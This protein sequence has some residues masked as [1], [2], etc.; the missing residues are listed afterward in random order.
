MLG[1]GAGIVVVMMA[2]VSW[3]SKYHRSFHVDVNENRK[4]KYFDVSLSTY[5][6]EPTTYLRGLFTHCPYQEK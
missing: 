2:L 3:N 4:L 5:I 1:V 6:S